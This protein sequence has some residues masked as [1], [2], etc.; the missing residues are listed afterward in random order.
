MAENAGAEDATVT[1]HVKSSGGQKYTLSL[2]LSTTTLDLK[3]KLAA[4]EYANVPASAQRLIYSGKVLKDGDTLASHNVKEGNTMHLVKSAASNQRQNP[5][6]QSTTSTPSS[7][8]A[9]AVPGVPTNL[10]SGTGND[11]LTAFTG[12]RYA[13]FTQMPNAS[14][15]TNPQTPEDFIRQLEDPN[16]QQVMREAMNNPQVIDMMINQNPQ[17]RN[18]PGIRQILQSDD[19]RRMMTDPQAIRAMMR[20]QGGAGMNPFGGGG[21]EA[22]FPA[23]GVTNTTE[24]AGAQGDN[25]TQQQQQMPPNPFAA[26][27]GGGGGAGA[28]PFASLFMPPFPS[29]N[30]ATPGSPPPS[31]TQNEVGNRDMQNQQPN[32]FA[33]LMNPALFGQQQPGATGATPQIP[34]GNPFAQP[35]NPEALNSFLQALG[36]GAGGA[37]AEGGNYGNLF[38]FLGGAGG[39]GGAPAAPADNRPPEERYA[40]QLQQLNDMGFFDFDRNVQALRRAGGNVNGAIEYLLSNP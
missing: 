20:L 25:Q 37:G 5:A 31:G 32:P 16:F 30:T 27:G 33:A 19:F 22:A 10:A 7:G 3:N 38:D 14:M 24:N 6:A 13:G 28:N 40:T 15:F 1:F 9:L 36:G 34:G 17:L 8:P 23:P 26:F 11:P 12:A 18:M 21:G 4:E 35:P 29:Q 39:A 2:P